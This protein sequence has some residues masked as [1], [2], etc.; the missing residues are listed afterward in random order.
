MAF[1]L[2]FGLVSSADTLPL[3]APDSRVIRLE[4]FF[5]AHH[6]P[7]P[8]L[9]ADYVSVADAYVLDYRLLPAVS[10][11]ESTCG[12]HARLN[13]RWG[14]NSARTGFLSLRHGIEFVT[15]Q[16]AFGRAYRGKTLEGKLHAYNPNPLYPSEIRRLMREI[17]SD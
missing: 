11:R 5:Q 4:M 17:D 15:R 13:N 14:W 8:F 3:T 2:G 7:A 10:V 9:T 1:S 12:L 16:L 6:C